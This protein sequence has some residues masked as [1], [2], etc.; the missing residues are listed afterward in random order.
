MIEDKISAPIEEKSQSI[1]GRGLAVVI[2]ALNE[3]DNIGAVVAGV[4]I[5]AQVIVVDDGSTDKTATVAHDAG[6]HVIS[7]SINLGYDKALESGIIE[8]RK[9]GCAYAITMDADGQHDPN[10]LLQFLR[11]LESGAEVVVGIRDHKQRWSETL[12]S[13]ISRFAWGLHDPLCGM[14]A[15]CISTIPVKYEFNTYTS[16]GT[17]LAIRLI[18]SGANLRQIN[19]N[20][21]PRKGV[22]RFGTG[23]KANLTILKAMLLGLRLRVDNISIYSA[24]KGHK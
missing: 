11:E 7:H 6:A 23:V 12:F 5:N 17:E 3:A 10:L 16:V 14:K 1:S 9:L 13:Y 19:I 15:Y 20:T 2:P 24:S 8:A 21:P 4:I 18:K 22:S